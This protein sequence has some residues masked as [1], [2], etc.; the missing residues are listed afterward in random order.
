M[1]AGHDQNVISKHIK[2]YIILNKRAEQ[3]TNVERD[4]TKQ[5]KEV[6]LQIGLC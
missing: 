1:I 2:K 5:K 3:G 4:T 6:K